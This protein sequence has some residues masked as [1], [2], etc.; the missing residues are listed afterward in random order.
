MKIRCQTSLITSAPM[1]SRDPGC[2]PAP[3][4]PLPPPGT[5]THSL[6]GD[7][8]VSAPPG[9]CIQG[10]TPKVPW[11]TPTAHCT[12]LPAS[13]AQRRFASRNICSPKMQLNLLGK[14]DP[15]KSPKQVAH[16]ARQH[17]L[18]PGRVGVHGVWVPPRASPRPAGRPR[19]PC[20][21]RPHARSARP[22]ARGRLGGP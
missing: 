15:A 17:P 20:A 18:G 19:G 21:R 5:P 3:F 10:G 8:R 2:H 7:E 12:S 1:P 16:R 14:V 9:P 13:Q 4:P 6:P 22:P 11:P